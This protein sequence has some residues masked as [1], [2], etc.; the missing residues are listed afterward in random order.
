MTPWQK[1]NLRYQKEKGDQPVWSPSV[2]S[3]IHSDEEQSEDQTEEKHEE[4]A[5][6][7]DSE[8]APRSF[9]DRLPN[10]K[11]YRNRVL[12]RR[13]LLIIGVLLIPLL[14]ILYY[15]SPLS[16]LADVKVVGN[17]QVSAQSI[18]EHSELT[19]GEEIWPQYFD[20]EQTEHQKSVASC[21]KCS[22]DN[23]FFKPVQDS[24]IGVPRGGIASKR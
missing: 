15:V 7:E 24:G 2:I 16:K 6:T 10:L 12:L 19:T 20:S 22:S 21:Q 4:G 9:A 23:H 8:Q 3:G 13:L 1:E 11:K 14:F 18:I 17:D 5:E